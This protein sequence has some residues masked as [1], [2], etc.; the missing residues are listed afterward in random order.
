MDLISM[1]LNKDNWR[2]LLQ[3]G[4]SLTSSG[5]TGASKVIFQTPEKLVFANSI[6]LEAQKISSKSRI[7]T[8]CNMDHAGGVLAQT[9]PALSIGAHVSVKPFN[10]YRF[11]DDIQGYTH[12]HLTPAHCLALTHTKQLFQSNLNGLSITCGSTPVPFHIIETFVRL[13]ARFMCNWGMTEIGPIVIN[14]TFNS[15]E[16]VN[17]YKNRAC[18]STT[19]MGDCY[20]CDTKIINKVLFVKGEQCVFDGWF[21]TRDLVNKNDQGAIYFIDRDNSEL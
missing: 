21:N 2:S 16:K 5:T 19:L 8:V 18:D 10:A 20:Y 14:T 4:F 6:A 7:L 17:E 1:R 3:H 15:L 11:L 9:L 13:G 12:T